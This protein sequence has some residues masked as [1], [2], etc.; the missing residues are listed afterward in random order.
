MPSKSYKIF[1]SECK[2]LALHYR[3]KG[4]GSLIR[5]YIQQILDPEHFKNY[6]HAKLKAE[7]PY[8]DCSKCG[9]KIG[10]PIIHNPGSRPAYKMIKGSFLK[11]KA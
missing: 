4:S 2:G 1:C 9:Q 3:K 10:V 8:L 11:K 6:K 5:I 7:I